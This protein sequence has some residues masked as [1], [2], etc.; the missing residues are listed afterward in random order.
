MDRRRPGR[1]AGRLGDPHGFD[2]VDRDDRVERVRPRARSSSTRWPGSRTTCRR[3]AA[4][5]RAVR[6]WRWPSSPLAGLSTAGVP[7]HR[8]SLMVLL[9][10]PP[11]FIQSL[12]LDG[13]HPETLAVPFLIGSR[14]L[15]CP[16]TGGGSPSAA[17][18]RCC[19][20]RTS[21]W[22]SPVSGSDHGA[23]APPGRSPSSSAW[24]GLGFL[25]VQPTSATASPAAGLRR[26]G[27]TPDR[28]SGDAHPSRRASRRCSR[29]Q[30]RVARVPVRP[31]C[32]SRSFAA[33]P[34]AGRAAAGAVPG[35]RR[36]H[37]HPLRAAVGGDHLVHLPGHPRG[38]EPARPQER[39]EVSIDRRV[40]IT[41]AAPPSRS[42][43]SAPARSTSNRGLGR[44]GRGRRARIEATQ[45]CRDAR[46]RAGI[47]AVQ[48]PI[49]RALRDLGH[50]TSRRPTWRT[51][52]ATSTP[53]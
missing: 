19:A 28:S 24:L 4:A 11:R 52:P 37:G 6:R 43:C 12:N 8:A 44:P 41:M 53:S 34:P 9:V 15:G 35:R 18:W 50:R 23:G 38:A 10:T 47:D 30:R 7:A 27:D 40:L 1:P 20:G 5:H 48:P 36:H 26:V 2:P 16:S 21:V 31:G 32:S 3:A 33:V 51:S 42:L 39:G 13:F 45:P 22:P 49:G 29:A 46:V 25:W 17:C 14:L